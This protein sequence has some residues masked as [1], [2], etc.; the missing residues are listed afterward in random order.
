V[1]PLGVQQARF[2]ALRCVS[3]AHRAWANLLARNP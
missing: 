3:N 2:L 1:D